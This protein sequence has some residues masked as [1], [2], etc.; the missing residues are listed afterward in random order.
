MLGLFSLKGQAA[1]GSASGG[2]SGVGGPERHLQQEK[3]SSG[4]VFGHFP[5]RVFDTLPP[6]NTAGWGAL[7]GA[8]CPP[9]QPHSARRPAWAFQA[10]RPKQMRG[11]MAAAEHAP[12]GMCACCVKPQVCPAYRAA[13]VPLALTFKCL[14]ALP[15]AVTP[16]AAAVP[17]SRAP[18]RVC[19][20]ES[21]LTLPR[22]SDAIGSRCSRRWTSSTSSAGCAALARAGTCHVCRSSWAVGSATRTSAT[23][24]TTRRC[25]TRLG[26]GTRRCAC[27]CWASARQ[28]MQLQARP[29]P[30]LFTAPARQAMCR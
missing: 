6:G 23:R 3:L 18:A 16:R 1:G 25:T 15:W 24:P 30:P 5:K 10:G 27:C 11:D 29:V 21:G 4:T 26:R 2:G 14:L 19:P 17:L 28:W 20:G 13:N 22:L 8:V 12:S 7:S 9:V